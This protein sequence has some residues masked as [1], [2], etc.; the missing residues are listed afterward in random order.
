MGQ[1]QRHPRDPQSCTD[2]AHERPPIH[3]DAPLGTERDDED[4]R[5]DPRHGADRDGPDT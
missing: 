5:D 3:I 1:H 4:Q 2:G